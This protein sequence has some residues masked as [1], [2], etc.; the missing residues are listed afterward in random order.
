MWTYPVHRRLR[1][2]LT[3]TATRN[4]GSDRVTLRWTDNANNE[5]GFTIQRATN[6]TFTAGL[7][8]TTAGANA[9]SV[10]LNGVTR[11]RTYFYRVQATNGVGGSAWSNVVSV[12]TP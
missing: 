4:G 2:S 7:Q 11:N 8:S 3:A 10:A 12:T 9:T 6:D 5:S 1:S